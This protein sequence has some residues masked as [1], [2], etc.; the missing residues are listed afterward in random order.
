MNIRINS[1]IIIGLWL[2]LWF[3][4]GFAQNVQ[5]QTQRPDIRVEA[6][7]LENAY[8]ILLRNAL[9]SYFDS[10]SYLVDVNI[11]LEETLIPRE[12]ER[13]QAIEQPII[14]DRLPG[15]PVIPDNLTRRVES[16]SDSIAPSRF[17][18][19][20]QIQRLMIRI[21]MESNYTVDD[22]T[23]ARDLVR[24]VAK[25]DDFRGDIVEISS[26]NFPQSRQIA[27]SIETEPATP[28]LALSEPLIQEEV[29]TYTEIDL[30]NIPI[31]AWI[32]TGAALILFIILILYLL[33]RKKP[34]VI[35]D[36]KTSSEIALL[37][38]ELERMKN[39]AHAKEA[40]ENDKPSKEELQRYDADKSFIINQFIGN[41]EKV[42][43][44]FTQW[45]ESEETGVSA[46]ARAV[47]AVN[48]KLIST[49]RSN[50]RE[51]QYKAI[52]DQILSLPPV[53]LREK[54]Q[55]LN[56]FRKNLEA[57]NGEKSKRDNDMFNFLQQMT[58]E[59]LLHLIKDESEKMAAII[60]AQLEGQ[61]ASKVMKTLSDEK[62]VSIL[63]KMGQ[64]STLPVSAYKQ[65]AEHFAS[66]ALEVSN[67]RFVTADGVQSIMS[68]LD[69]L[70]ISEQEGYLQSITEN[71]LDLAKR[72]R[73]F[74][75]TFSEIPNIDSGILTMALENIKTE[76]LA[77]ALRDVDEKFYQHIINFRP[78]RERLLI[79]SEIEN[80]ND[81]TPQEI[82]NARRHLLQEIRNTI[83][84]R[85]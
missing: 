1:N 76:T 7:R 46:V 12:F 73:K 44:L 16:P 35:V 43:T 10:D 37:K 33:L 23:F 32:V 69:S 19:A 24:G 75:V 31:W 57:L 29:A 21:I 38:S 78:A 83:K 62:R 61:R 6:A 48:P 20:L 26:R 42:V 56:K 53:H 64:I 82:E 3:T 41:P 11:L 40:A 79:R 15:L 45:I 27:T 8:E 68:V 67:M 55:E 47:N 54:M 63:L 71:D 34:E 49:M 77:N 2:T 18:R 70:P 66:K 17:D 81:V 65:V 51:D 50:L 5:T 25:V 39:E 52:E 80:R 30:S 85:S 59:Q 9:G 58:D 36:P 84:K 60:L 4:N 22:R 13:A 72:I 74:Y 28:E 14:L